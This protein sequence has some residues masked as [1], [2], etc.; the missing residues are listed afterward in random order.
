MYEKLKSKSISIFHMGVVSC[1]K[2]SRV[3]CSFDNHG[4]FLLKICVIYLFFNAKVNF[5]IN[6][7]LV[8]HHIYFNIIT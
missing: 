2:K 6:T 7:P 5:H 8:V 1:K 4:M 3:T